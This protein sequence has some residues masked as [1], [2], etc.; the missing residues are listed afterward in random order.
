MVKEI[1]VVKR[2]I[3]NFRRTIKPQRSILESL[4]SKAIFNKDLDLKTRI[5]DIIGTNIRV[6]NVLENHKET[7]D[8]LEATNDSLFSHRL[9]EIM[10]TLTVFS[11]ILLPASL[12]VN[13]LGVGS[14]AS[15]EEFWSL[16]SLVLILMLCTFV[17]IKKKRWL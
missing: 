3:Q 11:V 14:K 15:P 1:S 17:V 9:S 2:D 5:N 6:W 12:F 10:K 13:L 16:L 4:H 8:S 7:I